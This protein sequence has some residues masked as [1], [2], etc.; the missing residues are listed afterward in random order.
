MAKKSAVE[1]AKTQRH[2]FLLRKVQENKTLSRAE[3][4]ELKRYERQAA[5]KITA[6]AR[7]T[8]T[9]P[10]TRPLKTRRKKK[11]TAASKRG[12]KKRERPSGYDCLSMR[13][14]FAGWDSNTRT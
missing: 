6:K 9:K 1:I 2:V 12:K 10:S 14:R 8:S 13:R 11:V 7:I 5:S 4:D 3:M